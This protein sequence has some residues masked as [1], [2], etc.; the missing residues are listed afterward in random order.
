M[1]FIVGLAF[2]IFTMPNKIRWPAG[3][4]DCLLCFFRSEIKKVFTIFIAGL[5]FIIMINCS[6]VDDQREAH[7][8][9]PL[10]LALHCSP[11]SSAL[12]RCTIDRDCALDAVLADS[13]ADA[14]DVGSQALLPET[15]LNQ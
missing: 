12:R 6:F 9:K 15:A 2:T 5:A 13:G 11:G 1:I 10:D 3:K 14:C 7:P 4:F 8:K